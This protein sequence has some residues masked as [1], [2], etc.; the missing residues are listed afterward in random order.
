M[1]SRA[2]ALYHEARRRWNVPA[3]RALRNAKRRADILD[4]WE[5][6]IL[7]GKVQLRVVVD[8]LATFD[9]VAGD[10]YRVELHAD[11]VPG[12]ERTI[13]AEEKRERARVDSEGI[14]GIVGEY[15]CPTCGSWVAADSCWGFIGNDWAGSGYD[16]DIMA[17]TL[18]AV[19]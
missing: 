10:T 18:D 5:A 12:G 19:A 7:A 8:E 17:A 9:D 13:R 2:M 4:R 14:W 3:S 1:N 16:E 11:T 6:A 15:Q